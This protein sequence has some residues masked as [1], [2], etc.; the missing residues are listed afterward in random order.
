MISPTQATVRRGIGVH[1]ADRVDAS[2]R[3]ALPL[4]TDIVAAVM[5]GRKPPASFRSSASSRNR[6]AL[7]R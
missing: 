6:F 2:V 1:D 7:A 3:S 4:S 5:I